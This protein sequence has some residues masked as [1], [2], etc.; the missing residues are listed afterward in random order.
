MEPRKLTV[1][2]H[3]TRGT[4]ALLAS[5]ALLVV[6]AVLFMTSAGA[7]PPW[8][9][10]MD[11]VTDQEIDV[12]DIDLNPNWKI[13]YKT[14]QENWYSDSTAWGQVISIT[15]DLP[16]PST[17][18]YTYTLLIMGDAML[19]RWGLGIHYGGCIGLS[20]NDDSTATSDT[21][22]CTFTNPDQEVDITTTSNMYITQVGITPTAT[23]TVYLLGRRSTYA[24]WIRFDQTALTVLVLDGPTSTFLP[25]IM[26]NRTVP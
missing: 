15:L 17:G 21:L 14:E 3:V 13:Y 25:V 7:A 4:V 8:Q 10:A 18:T 6:L 19:Y 12:A 5:L 23:S 1:E 26:D 16:R 2:I 22:R 9:E 24:T 20:V 11:G